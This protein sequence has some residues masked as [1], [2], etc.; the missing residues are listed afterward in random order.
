MVIKGQ[1]YLQV[2][3]WRHVFF[4]FLHCNSL[5]FSPSSPTDNLHEMSSPISG[6]SKKN[7]NNSVVSVVL[8]VHT[9]N[10]GSGNFEI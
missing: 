4:L 10:Q 8:Q 5:F 3:K 1:H 6:K 7:L 9:V 2:R